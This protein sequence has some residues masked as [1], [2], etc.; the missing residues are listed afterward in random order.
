[1]RAAKPERPDSGHPDLRRVEPHDRQA[2]PGSSPQGMRAIGP[3]DFRGVPQLPRLN[4][5]RS[6]PSRDPAGPPPVFELVRQIATGQLHSRRTLAEALDAQAAAAPPARPAPACERCKDAGYLVA[7]APY[8]DPAF[9]TLI[10]CP[11]QAPAKHAARRAH[12]LQLGDLARYR[13]KTFATFRVVGVTL[14]AVAKEARLF[15][16]SPTGF[17]VLVGESGTG[18]THLAAAVANARFEAGDAVLFTV[19]PDL[20][21]HLR[22]SYNWRRR[23]GDDD[24]DD[25]I[26]YDALLRRCRDADLL[27]LDDLGAESATDWAREKLFQIVNHRVVARL[28]TVITTN[29]RPERIDPRLRSR[30]HE[31]LHGG[32]VWV[33][34]APDYRRRGAGVAW[35]SWRPGISPGGATAD[36]AAAAFDRGEEA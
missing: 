34:A 25:S 23:Q 3:G 32:R 27:V 26:G 8:G 4:T 17:L 35:E 20:L 21:D 22:A 1:M 19:V 14:H 11:C 31:H 18:K 33:I 16:E 15:A 7:D 29:Q 5:V 28:P 10:P 6:R 30:A 2:S 9:G 36:H 13:D 12:L 24:D